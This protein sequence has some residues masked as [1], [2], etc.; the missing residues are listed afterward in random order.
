MLAALEGGLGDSW[1]SPFVGSVGLMALFIA[2]GP[3][4]SRQRTQGAGHSHT[5]VL[6]WKGRNRRWFRE[7]SC[8]GH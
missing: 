4:A 2:A 3:R 6:H 5:G 7:M 8:A 1:L